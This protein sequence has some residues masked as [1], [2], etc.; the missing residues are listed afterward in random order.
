MRSLFWNTNT[1]YIFVLF[2]VAKIVKNRKDVIMQR[3]KK[4]KLILLA[5]SLLAGLSAFSGMTVT[6]AKVQVNIEAGGKTTLIFQHNEIVLP[7]VQGEE[8]ATLAT[9]DHDSEELLPVWSSTPGTSP[10]CDSCAGGPGEGLAPHEGKFH[11]TVT[12][13][14]NPNFGV[15]KVTLTDGAYSVNVYSRPDDGSTDIWTPRP[16]LGPIPIPLESATG[17]V[18][19]TPLLKLDNATFQ[20]TNIHALKMATTYGSNGTSD[21]RVP[22]FISEQPASP[23]C[24]TWESSPDILANLSI[25][26]ALTKKVSAKIRIKGIQNGRPGELVY[27]NSVDLEG[28]SVSNK[29]FSTA[30]KLAKLID[31]TTYDLTWE[32][33]VDNGLSYIPIITTS[34]QLFVTAGTPTGDTA[35]VT[36]IDKVTLEAKGLFQEKDI[37]NRLF[38]KVTAKLE[39]RPPHAAQPW[40]MLDQSMNNGDC[41]SITILLE[42]MIH[43]LGINPVAGSAIIY[44]LPNVP[45]NPIP[46]AFFV[47]NATDYTTRDCRPTQNDH[48]YNS[49]C[50]LFGNNMEKYNYW[51]GSR[52]NNFQACFQY[53]ENVN[54][55]FV[56]YPGGDV[57]SRADIV[58]VMNKVCLGMRWICCSPTFE[59]VMPCPHTPGILWP[60]PPK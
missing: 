21:V 11:V 7:K 34:N 54:E 46:G 31:N 5:T 15:Y 44:I 42:S 49:G 2:R 39:I 56:Y 10:I 50:H 53:R 27:E 37:V 19:I 14:A 57:L 20:G 29:V 16:D 13:N 48:P 58:A 3:I 30:N 24:Y 35:T 8:F 60:L 51:D 43:M 52:Y 47:M 38:E 22:H 28:A 55:N 4:R 17:E 45:P 12:Q 6:P 59:S 23:I 32:L 9:A 33:S 25:S 40:A 36:R 1:K 18:H 26:P 41:N